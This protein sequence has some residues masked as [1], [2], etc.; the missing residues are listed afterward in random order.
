MGVLSRGKT[1]GA[2][3]QQL[4][5]DFHDLVDEATFTSSAVDGTSTEL[6]GGAIAVKDGGI[7]SAKIANDAVG[8]DQIDSEAEEISI[9]SIAAINTRLV[10]FQPDAETTATLSL[11]LDNGNAQIITLDVAAGAITTVD[12][13]ANM[14]AGEQFTIII[15]PLNR[16]HTIAGWHSTWKW[17]GGAA[18]AI[19]GTAD[20]IDIISGI[21]DG[22]NAYVTM[23][24]NFA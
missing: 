7:T 4:T 9:S 14:T 1:W 23:L 12:A 11:N 5:S 3:E 13:L 16:T 18:P 19:T 6:S 22:T 21:S 2:T 8:P 15:K 24:K 20:S 17:F 10:A